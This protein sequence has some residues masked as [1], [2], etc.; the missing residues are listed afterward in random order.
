MK[1]L[2]LILFIV[3]SIDLFAQSKLVTKN[4]EVGMPIHIN[5][6]KD[7]SFVSMDIY[8]KTRF[9]ASGIKI[10]TLTGD[11]VFENFFDPGDFDV[12]RLPSSYGNQNYK[13]AAL[14]VYDEKDGSQRRVM[15]C[16]T[17]S[18]LSMIWIEIDKAVELNEVEF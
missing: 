9:P 8:T 10:D 17:Q 5:K 7:K 6:C 11:G 2:F 16:Y 4:I 15:I 18:K 1:K 3:S 12:K 14:R 13:I